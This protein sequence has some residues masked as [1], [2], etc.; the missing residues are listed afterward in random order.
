MNLVLMYWFATDSFI[1]IMNW[2]YCF[3]AELS[4]KAPAAA[5]AHMI[6]A[7][8][9]ALLFFVVASPLLYYPHQYHHRLK[10]WDKQVNKPN[11]QRLKGR[12][13]WKL[14]TVL[15]IWVCF[16]STFP[17]FIIEFHILYNYGW[18][19]ILQGASFLVTLITA[20]SGF[21][22][23]WGTYLWRMSKKLQN[24][25]VNAMS[26]EQRTAYLTAYT[27]GP[28]A[29]TYDEYN[30]PIWASSQS[31]PPIFRLLE[32]T[33]GA[34]WGPEIEDEPPPPVT[35]NLSGLAFEPAPEVSAYIPADP[36]APSVAN[37]LRSQSTLT[38]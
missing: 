34:T 15:G 17:R 18:M 27:T 13:A 2:W 12:R 23:V 5:N 7:L 38:S 8:G 30:R 11:K 37:I 3:S 14:H 21:L 25:T 35:T 9:G 26:E 16:L 4:D 33:A 10:Q 29:I 6:F 24:M 32:G 31:L 20:G 22:S 19:K 36:D 1:A 28:Y